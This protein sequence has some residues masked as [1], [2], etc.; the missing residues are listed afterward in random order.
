MDQHASIPEIVRQNERQELLVLYVGWTRAMARLILAGRKKEFAGGILGLLTIST[1]HGVVSMNPYK[2]N[3]KAFFQKYFDYPYRFESAVRKTE[4]NE[5]FEQYLCGKEIA[6]LKQIDH[7]RYLVRILDKYGYDRH[8]YWV[9]PCQERDEIWNS[10]RLRWDTVE[11]LWLTFEMYCEH[12]VNLNR[13][14]KAE[15][16]CDYFYPIRRK[17]FSNFYPLTF[18]ALC[19]DPGFSVLLTDNKLKR[20]VKWS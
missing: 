20:L 19:E 7:P 12:K 8:F 1:T 9:Y 16:E 5:Y 14:E 17:L 4:P 10:A 18:L 6:R 15:N 11:G 2:K 3:R 13:Y